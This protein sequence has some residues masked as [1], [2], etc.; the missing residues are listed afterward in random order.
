MLLSQMGCT[1]P[2]PFRN[3]LAARTSGS[4]HVLGTD[5]KPRPKLQRPS[6]LETAGGKD[7]NRQPLKLLV[8]IAGLEPARVTPLPP[9]SSASANSAICASMC[10]KPAVGHFCKSICRESQIIFRRV[11]HM[12]Q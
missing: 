2:S 10:K 4:E 8:R 9:Q 12:L 7:R 11:L 5:P 1:I 6:K 3:N